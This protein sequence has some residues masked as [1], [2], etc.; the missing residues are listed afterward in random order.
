MTSSDPSHRADEPTGSAPEATDVEKARLGRRS[1]AAETRTQATWESTV[2]PFYDG[3]SLMRLLAISTEELDRAS[4]AGEVLRTR[5]ADGTDLYPSFQ[6]N[7]S[8]ELLTGLREVLTVL[9]PG[10]DDPWGDALWLTAVVR[11]FEGRSAAKL[12]RMGELRPVQT[13]ARQ[14]RATWDR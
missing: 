6:L 4:N 11:R 3:A 2:E 10:L 1:S 13:A 9:D 14:D 7:A 12:M 8:A 5:T